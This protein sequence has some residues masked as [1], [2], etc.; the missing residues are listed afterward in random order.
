MSNPVHSE[1]LVHSRA[2]TALAAAP[3]T[4]T[5]TH[6]FPASTS[7]SAFFAK[8]TLP[9]VRAALCQGEN[10]L[11]FAYGVTNSGKTYTVQGA[12]GKDSA[13]ILPRTLDVIF[14]SIHGLQGEAR[15]C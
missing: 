10:G 14:N 15:A 13:G 9:L 3:T 6:I 8:T 12:S 2:S 1:A 11:V 5:F 4:Y 7:Q